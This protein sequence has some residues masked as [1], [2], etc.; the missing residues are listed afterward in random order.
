MKSNRSATAPALRLVDAETPA[1]ADAPEPSSRGARD[2]EALLE[3]DVDVDLDVGGEFGDD[4]EEALTAAAE[5]AA[6]GELDPATEDALRQWLQRRLSAYLKAGHRARIIF[7]D[8]VHTMLS[9]K[10]GQGVY[11]LRMHR[12]FAAAPPAVLRAVAR[13]AQSQDRDA[14]ALLRRY[15]DGNEHLIRD[16]EKP[17]T[18]QLD[19][20]GAHFNLQELFDDL[21]ARYFGGTIEAKITW[22][23]RTR[24]KPGR[25][26]IK[27]GSY[28]IE[29]RLIRVHPVLDAADVPR[30]FV[31]WIIYHEMLHEVHD[32]PIVDGRRV[33]HTPEFRRAEALFDRYA[34]AVL[35]ERTQVH[36]LLDR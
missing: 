29:E 25:E 15:I 22:G 9:V 23:P 34:E 14:G 36:K 3:D 20:Q 19:T 18:Q 21:N 32:M 17:R 26:S 12:M 33:Y 27:L 2:A 5:R 30:F 10:R 16:A 11:T 6:V 8:N 35:W 31:E 1:E 28:S 4:L 7:T 13:Y 24:R